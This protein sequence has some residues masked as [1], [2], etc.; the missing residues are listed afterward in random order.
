MQKPVL[1][2]ATAE[3]IRKAKSSGSLTPDQPLAMSLESA[4]DFAGR[5]KSSSSSA[6]FTL[7]SMELPELV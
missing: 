6:D 1:E 4:E 7:Q 3:G 5:K 2:H